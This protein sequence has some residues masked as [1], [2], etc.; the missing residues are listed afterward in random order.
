VTGTSSPLLPPLPWLNECLRSAT[1][2]LNMLD[3]HDPNEIT[4]LLGGN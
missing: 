3:P 2:C 4:R 1:A